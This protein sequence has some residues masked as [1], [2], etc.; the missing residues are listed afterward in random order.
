MKLEESYLHNMEVQ[1]IPKIL[2]KVL[3]NNNNKSL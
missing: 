1:Q 3:A 2:E